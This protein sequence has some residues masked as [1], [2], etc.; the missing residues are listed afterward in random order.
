VLSKDRETVSEY[1]QT[2]KL[3]L[4]TTKT[5]SAVFHLN[6]KEAKRE[7]KVNFNNETLPFCSQ[8]KHLGVMYDSS[9]THR[10]HLELHRKKLTSRVALLRRLIGS[11]CGAGTTTLRTTTLALVHSTA[12][13]CPPIWCRSA[14]TRL[15][16]SSN[17]DALWIVSG[18]LR[19]TPADNL[20]ILA[21]I[22]PAE[23]RLKVHTLIF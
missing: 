14:H 11:G 23:L 5:V 21:C 2:W 13:Y 1:F 19:P 7:L 3:K 16:D 4:S 12:E 10:R 9:F 20:P 22:Q 15:I 17:N 6:N 18:C 8:P